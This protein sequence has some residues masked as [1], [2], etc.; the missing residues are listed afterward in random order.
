MDSNPFRAPSNEK[1]YTLKEI[2]SDKR[3]IVR[4]T[5]ATL[6]DWMYDGAVNLS[7]DHV[8]LETWKVANVNHTSLEAIERFITAQNSLTAR[9]QIIGGCMDGKE[10][11][12]SDHIE[13]T[14]TAQ[15]S[16][17]VVGAADELYQHR[18][19]TDKFGQVRHFLVW[20]GVDDHDGVIK[21]RLEAE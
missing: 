7:G 19:Y 14:T 17:D 5:Y 16:P 6:K 15:L 10:R 4:R 20:V 8:R 21:Q 18:R 9:C 11:A 12:I 3:N 2:Y 1:L 13:R